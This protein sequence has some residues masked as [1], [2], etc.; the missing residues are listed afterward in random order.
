MAVLFIQYLATDNNEIC[1][2]AWKINQSRFNILPNRLANIDKDLWN[3]A[4][5]AKFRPIWSHWSAIK[6]MLENVIDYIY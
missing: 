5:V 1:P 3:F 4:K 6:I 2:K